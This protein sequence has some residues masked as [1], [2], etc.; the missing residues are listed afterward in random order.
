MSL[1]R[2]TLLPAGDEIGYRAKH[3][4]VPGWKMYHPDGVLKTCKPGLGRGRKKCLT[5]NLIKIF[6]LRAVDV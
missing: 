1:A 3:L 4:Y 2:G 6:N 5:H